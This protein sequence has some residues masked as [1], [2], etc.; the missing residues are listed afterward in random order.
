MP[1][2]SDPGL[3]R[4]MSTCASLVPSHL[5]R[6]ARASRPPRRTLASL[7]LAATF[8]GVVLGADPVEGLAASIAGG[9]PNLE[10]R[11]RSETVEQDSLDERAE[12]LT[13]R[14]RLG[15]T[16]AKWNGLDG[17]LEYEGLRALGDDAHYNDSR[18]GRIERPMVSDPDADE[19]NQAWVRWSALPRTSLKLGR[20]RIV[21]DNARFVGN[22][23]WRQNE[24]TYDAALLTT[25]QVPRTTLTYA[26]LA[27][28]DSFRYFDFDPG[29]A[30]DP[31]N[32]LDI[33]A[34]L[35]NAGV[36][37]VEGRLKLTGYGYRLDFRE[38]PPGP[39][40]RLY[41]DTQ[42]YGL[43]ATG[44]LPL[45]SAVVSYAL[46]FATQG[47]YA[48]AAHAP[49]LH[50][51]LI[52]IALGLGT[53]KTTLGR[54]LLEGDGSTSFQT[55]LATAHAHQG[56]ADQF[57]ITP[58]DGLDRRYVGVSVALSKLSIS[59]VCHDFESA[60]GNTDYGDEFDVLASYALLNNLSIA[61]KLA[62]YS[63]D[64]YPVAG[65]SASASDTGK[66]WL[67]AEYKF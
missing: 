60:R 63:A 62:R 49:D 3:P 5:R 30:V 38:A 14:A 9:K 43:R 35:V 12:A 4:S 28:V 37:V 53:F 19:L 26:H 16:T 21:F 7:V 27:N 13:V 59:L 51:T 29:P 55:P 22:V 41:A 17:Q 18:N 11:V 6:T 8:P 48:D 15:Y 50:Y 24:A 57:V 2:S 1:A 66:N 47:D 65:A 39:V 25:Q 31:R 61:A 46:E 54:E 32:D 58:R 44:A 33:S 52:E 64:A 10:V 36:D 23:G 45:R 56:W 40:A 67:Y 42:T 34:H 20:Q